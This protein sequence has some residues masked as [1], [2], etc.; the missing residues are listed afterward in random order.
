MTEPQS[1]GWTQISH[2]GKDIKFLPLQSGVEKMYLRDVIEILSY[3]LSEKTKKQKTFSYLLKNMNGICIY[4]KV[5]YKYDR[6][7]VEKIEIKD[8]L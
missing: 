8:K 7:T 5:N 2:V 1:H 6:W 4:I 3:N